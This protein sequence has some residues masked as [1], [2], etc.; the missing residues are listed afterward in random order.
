MTAHGLAEPAALAEQLAALG[1]RPGGDLMVHASL[2]KLGPVVGGATGVVEAVRLALGVD[3]TMLMMVAAD[4]GEPFDRLT[5]PADP[6][7]GVLADVFR[8]HPGVEVNDHPACRFAA[9]GPAAADLLAPQPLDDYYGPG[10]PLERLTRRGGSVL[11]LGSDVDTVTLTHHAEYLAEV[12]GKRTVTR[13]YTRAD[14]GDVDVHSLDDSAGIVDWPHGDYFSQ[15]LLDYL[16]AGRAKVG[17]V[18]GCTAELL[19]ARD[20]V[21]YATSWMTEHLA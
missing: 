11:R 21:E 6:E 1:V 13:R 12:P 14:T 7:N 3:G 2:R 10:S 5:T 20:F 18:G 15:I 16:S 17:P 9:W 4:D 8:Q 19:D